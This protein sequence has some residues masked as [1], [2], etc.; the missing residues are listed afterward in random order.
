[1]HPGAVHT[2]F[3]RFITIPVVRELLDLISKFFIKVSFS[4]G[5]QKNRFKFVRPLISF[6][7]HNQLFF[8]TAKEGAQT[9]IH[10]A[11]SDEVAGVTGKY[12]DN[13]KV[14][15]SHVLNAIIYEK[16]KL[17]LAFHYRLANHRNN[18]K[19]PDWPKSYGRS[20]K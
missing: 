3:A 15:R 13:C 8:K 4:F 16:S 5:K 1:L 11:V 14:S 18:P 17:M 2:E 12:F 20:A 10:L 19:M 7:I 9:Q 6:D